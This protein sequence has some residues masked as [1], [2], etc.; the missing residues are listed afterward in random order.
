MSEDDYGRRIDAERKAAKEL[1]KRERLAQNPF[2]PRDEISADARH[3][4]NRI[5]LNLW[6][7]LLIIPLIAVILVSIG[8]FK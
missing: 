7:L 8:A 3:I 6:I 2:D 4:A 1:A 5:V